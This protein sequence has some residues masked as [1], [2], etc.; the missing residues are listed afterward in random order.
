MR[1]F[2]K[3]TLA[4][5]AGGVLLSSNALAYQ[6]NTGAGSTNQYGGSQNQNRIQ[7]S[8]QR[9]P[10]PSYYQ[11]APAARPPQTQFIPHPS[12]I[13]GYAPVPSQLSPQAAKKL[14]PCVVGGF[15]GGVG[16]GVRGAAAG[17]AAGM[18]G[19]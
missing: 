11:Q 14:G 8:Y 19:Q 10:T 9:Q 13:P 1:N 15:W 2:H 6:S 7:Q 3:K 17:C 4:V 18:A 12:R 16:G 5:V